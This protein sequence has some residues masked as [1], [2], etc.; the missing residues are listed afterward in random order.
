V[1]AYEQTGA[2]PTIILI[3]AALADRDGAREVEAEVGIER[4]MSTVP[5]ATHSCSGVRIDCF[6]GGF[7]AFS[8]IL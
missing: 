7:Q 4:G 3:S 6:Y 8:L 2:G 5:T 1:I